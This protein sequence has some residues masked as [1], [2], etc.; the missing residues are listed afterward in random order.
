MVIYAASRENVPWNFI[1]ESDVTHVNQTIAIQCHRCQWHNV[2]ISD[3]MSVNQTMARL[4]IWHMSIKPKPAGLDQLRR[5]IVTTAAVCTDS[6][7]AKPGDSWAFVKTSQPNSTTL[8]LHHRHA[9]H[10]WWLFQPLWEPVPPVPTLVSMRCIGRGNWTA[11]G[12]A[13]DGMNND[14]TCCSLSQQINAP[15]STH[16]WHISCN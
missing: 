7:T 6:N 16:R 11:W 5:R 15:C 8:N 9:A 1:D 4:P 2:E 13:L 10:V 12:E 14:Y 3:L